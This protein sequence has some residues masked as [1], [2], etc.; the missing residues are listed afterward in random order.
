MCFLR[1][2]MPKKNSDLDE[3]QETQ[4]DFKE[5]ISLME[6]LL[7]SLK[8]ISSSKISKKIFG[9]DHLSLEYIAH[10]NEIMF[11]VACPIEYKDLMEKQI[12]GF[13]SDAV[14]EETPEVNIFKNRKY[15]SG[16][17]LAMKKAFYYP[18]KT[19]Q[20][21]E[22]DPINTITNAFSKLQEDESAAIQILIKPTDDDWQNECSS[23]SSQMMEGKKV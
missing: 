16:A 5:V 23:V 8:S 11:Y 20:K 21:L 2:T 19:Y 1:V 7:S 6:Q 3:K 18:I 12:N 15:Y 4:R 13:Y 17:Y 10:E 9:Q 22:S 14:I